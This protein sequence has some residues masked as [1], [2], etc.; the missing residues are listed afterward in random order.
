[1]NFTFSIEGHGDWLEKNAYKFLIENLPAYIEI[2]KVFIGNDGDSIIA[3]MSNE[4]QAIIDLREN[5]S[6]YHYT[7]MESIYFI[8]LLIEDFRIHNLKVENFEEY[9]NVINKLMAI[10]AYSGRLRDNL[11]EC[12]ELM[13]G[14]DKTIIKMEYCAGL[15]E[16]YIQRSILLHGRKMPYAISIDKEFMIPKVGSGDNRKNNWHRNSPWRNVNTDISNF[17]YAID[18]YTSYISGLMPILNS[19]LFKLLEIVKLYITSNALII[20]LPIIESYTETSNSAS[21]GPQ[22]VPF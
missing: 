15:D 16:Y 13:T 5:F 20:Q 17:E 18:I 9:F 10:E 4:N 1:M 11:I 3:K 14:L 7:V 22:S 19:I 21:M 12:F 8:H 2:W 6:Q